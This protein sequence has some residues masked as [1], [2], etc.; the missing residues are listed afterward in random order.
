MSKSL[1]QILR[2]SDRAASLTRQL[3]AFGGQEVLQTRT[4]NLNT[5]LTD[6]LRL[7]RRTIGEDIELITRLWIRSCHNSRLDPDQVAQVIMNLAINSRDA[8]WRHAGDRDPQRRARSD[9]CPGPR[10]GPAWKLRDAGGERQRYGH[11]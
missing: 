9:L 2:A 3:L 5:V 10:A 6:T 1:L 11:R 7:L 8:E 4:V